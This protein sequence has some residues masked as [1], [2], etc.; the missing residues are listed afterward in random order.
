MANY[1]ASLPVVAERTETTSTVTYSDG[2]YLGKLIS[3][4]TAPTAFDVKLYGD[5]GV[6]E[7]AKG[8]T[9]VAL[10]I[11]TT[12]VPIELAETLF[13]NT[14][15][16]ATSSEPAQVAKASDDNA[17]Y[18]GFGFIYAEMV[19][20]TSNY[21]VKFYPKVK[22][23][24]PSESFNTQGETIAFG[25]PSLTATAENDAIQGYYELTEKFSSASAAAAELKSLLSVS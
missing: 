8:V 4:S 25:T 10:T 11:N 12:T 5:D 15:T 18:V 2:A 6:A 13:G 23:A 16:S 19:D 20:G 7:S 17:P 1:Q 24:A 22:F 3:V 14:Y 21:Y 9:N